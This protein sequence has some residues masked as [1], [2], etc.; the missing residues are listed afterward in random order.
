MIK[1]QPEKFNSFVLC[2][3]MDMKVLC[4]QS[5]E[6]SNVT[7]CSFVKCKLNSEP[8]DFGV[9]FEVQKNSALFSMYGY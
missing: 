2:W 3:E 8:P 7:K 5:K 6:V 4:Y 9:G 1:E